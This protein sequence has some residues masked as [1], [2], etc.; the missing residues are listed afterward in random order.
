MMNMEILFHS[1]CSHIYAIDQQQQK[2]EQK[3][4]NKNS[5]TQKII[6][7]RIYILLDK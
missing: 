2:H 3:H 4:D 6:A 1:I 5:T 7:F